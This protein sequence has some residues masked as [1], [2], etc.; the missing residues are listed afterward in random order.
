MKVKYILVDQVPDR[1]DVCPFYQL[2]ADENG[3][4]CELLDTYDLDLNRCPL[5]TENDL[6][7]Y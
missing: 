3:N 5:L 2:P 7:Q 6:S 1:C 4:D